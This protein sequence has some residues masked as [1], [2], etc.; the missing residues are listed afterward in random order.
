MECRRC[1]AVE[2]SKSK[3]EVKSSQAD[4]DVIEL[5]IEAEPG[6]G[7]EVRIIIIEKVVLKSY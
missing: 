5:L 2:E 1:K 7:G 3:R 4:V 6:A